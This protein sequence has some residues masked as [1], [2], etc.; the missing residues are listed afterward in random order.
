M[1]Y[2]SIQEIL[3]GNDLALEKKVDRDYIKDL[4]SNFG[5]QDPANLLFLSKLCLCKDRTVQKNQ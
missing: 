2:E 3:E 1:V 5:D 4:I